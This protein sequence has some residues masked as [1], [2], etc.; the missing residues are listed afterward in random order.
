MAS[1]DDFDEW[2]IK[3]LN[4][5]MPSIQ[6]HEVQDLPVSEIGIDSLNLFDLILSIEDKFD[7]EIP[8][9]DIDR[10]LTINAIRDLL[11]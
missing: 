5:L 7:I 2:L 3:E 4:I 11:K 10:S 8:I 6:W 1:I 9:E